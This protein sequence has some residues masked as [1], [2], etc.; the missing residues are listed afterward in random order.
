[1]IEITD[2]R[3]GMAIELDG[4][5]F[6]CQKYEH[7]KPGKGPAFVKLMLRNLKTGAQFEKR[8]NTDDKVKKA[9][10]DSRL[11]QYLYEDGLYHFMDQENFETI[12][13]DEKMLGSDVDFLEDNMIITIVMY[14]GTPVGMELPNFIESNIVDT[15][16]GVRG[17]T[18]SG[19]SKP[20]TIASGA[21]IS[22]PLF[23]QIGDRVRVD[24]R[25]REYVTR[26]TS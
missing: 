1:M 17:D 11:A 20:A 19:G 18:A 13:L 23:V 2:V 15:D 6:V 12:D 24:T 5:L 14:E 4:E 3:Q 21:V 8:F 9:F 26:V 10:L 7:Y 25:K 16:P 22:V